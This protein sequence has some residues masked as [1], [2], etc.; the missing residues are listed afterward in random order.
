MIATASPGNHDWLRE[1]GAEP[2]DYNDEHISARV[3]EEGGADAAIDLFGGEGRRQ[4]F[5]C[6]RSG[7]R[8]VSIASPPPEPSDVA[9]THYV[10]VRPSGFD[11]HELAE[12]VDDGRL[13]P[14]VEEA[15]PLERA[16]DAHERIEGGHTRGKIVLSVS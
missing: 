3:R 14:H 2:L 16:A 7:G 4:A 15:F 8:L 1:L 10:F 11:L 9:E 13:K 5:A 6:L 12:L